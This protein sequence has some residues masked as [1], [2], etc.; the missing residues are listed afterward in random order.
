VS[1]VGPNVINTRELPV[2]PAVAVPPPEVVSDT[3]WCASPA[4]QVGHSVMS[5]CDAT[6]TEREDCAAWA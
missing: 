3:E 6:V 4:G 2:N 1:Y 5:F